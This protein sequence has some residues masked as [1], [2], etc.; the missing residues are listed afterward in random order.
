M[1]FI[2]YKG[3]E[4]TFKIIRTIDDIAFQTNLLALNAA[5]EAAR[6][7]EAGAGFAVVADEVR[8]LAGRAAEAARETTVLI[9][10]ST[11]KVKGGSGMVQDA[12]RSY[13]EVSESAA[14]V[15]AMISEITVASDEQALGVGKIREEVH[16]VDAIAQ[17][18]VTSSEELASSADT[19]KQQAG[20][21]QNFVNEL[22]GLMEG[23]DE[24][25]VE[26]AASSRDEIDRESRYL[27]ES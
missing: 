20:L 25:A 8:N 3:S 2:F 10:G 9:E 14:K 7:G 4:Q 24:P 11:E 15:G 1:L 26:S 22:V 19:L 6:A 17:R 18:N 21:L 23:A 16:E 27:P 5:V 12:S 13:G